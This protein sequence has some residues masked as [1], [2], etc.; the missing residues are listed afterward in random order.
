MRYSFTQDG[1]GNFGRIANASL[2]YLDGFFCKQFRDGRPPAM[3]DAEHAKRL[4]ESG[5]QP[6]NV[7]LIKSFV[8]QQSIDRHTYAPAARPLIVHRRP[9]HKRENNV[10]E[11]GEKLSACCA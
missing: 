5:D 3:L 2:R 1:S 8:L 10:E 9:R 6:V 7:I 4:V 11:G